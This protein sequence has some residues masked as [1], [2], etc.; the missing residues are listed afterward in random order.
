MRF[1]N[2]ADYYLGLLTAAEWHGAS[3][4]AVQEVQVVTPRQLRAVTL[5][6]ERIRFVRKRGAAATPVEVR[7]TDAGTVRV[8]SPEA[9]AIDLVRYARASGGLVVVATA[10]AE[11]KL[12]SAELKKALDGAGE[13]AVAQRVGYLLERVGQANAAKAVAAW[14]GRKA[15]VQPCAL[16]PS[17]PRRGAELAQPWRVLVNADVHAAA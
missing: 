2:A 8:S 6:R 10:L 15:R 5:G 16:D 12:R 3:H 14:L 7:T 17:A 9:T 4:F 1:L 13:V 11:L